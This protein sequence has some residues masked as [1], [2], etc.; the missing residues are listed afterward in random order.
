MKEM[1]RNLDRR[2][3]YVFVFLGVAIPMFIP[4]TK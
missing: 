2:V 3:V 1:L 4:F